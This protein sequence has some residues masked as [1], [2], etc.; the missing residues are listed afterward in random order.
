MSSNFIPNYLPYASSVEFPEYDETE[1][2]NQIAQNVNFALLNLPEITN[3]NAIGQLL[4]NVHETDTETMKTYLDENVEA[5]AAH[6]NTALDIAYSRIAILEARL[7]ALQGLEARVN[8]LQSQIDRIPAD[9]NA[10]VA[11]TK[12]PEPPTYAGSENKMQLEDWLNQ[13]AL[14]CAASGIVTDH[15]K[16]IC[17]LTRLRAPASTYMKDYFAKVQADQ[18]LGTWDN[19]IREL[20]NI[21]GQRDDKEGAKKELT[22]IWAN[23]EL[24][25][26]N[27]V[28]FVE[29]YRTL[30]RIVEYPDEVHI[31]KLKD[32]IPDELRKSLI[33][34]EINNLAPKTWD[35]YLQLLL[36]A[37]KLLHPDKAQGII[38]GDSGNVS[39]SGNKDPNAMEIDQAKKKKTKEASLQEKVQKYCQIC[40]GKGH[41]TKSKTHNTND[42]Y[43][44]PGNEGKRPQKSTQASSSKSTPSSSSGSS[45]GT[46]KNKMFKTRL[47]EFLNSWDDDDPET[48]SEVVTAN[49]ATIEEIPDSTPVETKAIAQIDDAPK[50]SRKPT[51]SKKLKGRS[52]MDFPEGL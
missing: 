23:K 28:K 31:D 43:D 11:K 30:A 21:Y 20:K 27:F 35:E 51:G 38:F 19:F 26:K 16:I 50:E 8:V 14:F 13:M 40:A 9:T 52:Q 15:Q 46:N 24:A 1:W 49:S 4:R 41:K 22:A 25:K 5:L 2:G 17:A 18:N 47:V 29:R 45:N 48:P 6:Y 39:G 32:V 10:G 37:Y 42:C 34:Y 3:Q 44:K 36:K 33:M 7:S 12:I